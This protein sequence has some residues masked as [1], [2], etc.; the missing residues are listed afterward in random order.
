MKYKR[1]QLSPHTSIETSLDTNGR[2][3]IAYCRGASVFIRDTKE[4]RRF[5]KLPKGI[6]SRERFDE[7]LGEIESAD[8][9]RKERK[10]AKE[11]L[12]EEL[13]ATGWGPEVHLDESDPN[14]ATKTVI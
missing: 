11:G 2:F 5:L 14:Y 12:S 4:L 1:L 9:A 7:W 8:T 13:L 10:D 6:P 3:W